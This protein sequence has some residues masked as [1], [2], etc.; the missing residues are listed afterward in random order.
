MQCETA[1]FHP[2][3]QF[4]KYLLWAAP[5]TVTARMVFQPFA[6]DMT[7]IFNK[8]DCSVCFLLVIVRGGEHKLRKFI[9]L[10]LWISLW[11]RFLCRNW[12]LRIQF[13]FSQ[14][15]FQLLQ[16]C[17]LWLSSCHWNPL[18]P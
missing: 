11:S 18:L 17:R 9:I 3:L 2:V 4:Q 6:L 16:S 10:K 12:L 8:S 5:A 7:Q 13:S 1:C 14:I 15:T